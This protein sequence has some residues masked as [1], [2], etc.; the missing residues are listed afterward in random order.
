MSGV[1][2]GTAFLGPLL[3]LADS[4]E[5]LYRLKILNET[6]KETFHE[7]FL[8]I[9]NL[10]TAK[11]KLS[12]LFQTVFT[13]PPGQNK[14]LFQSLTGYNFYCS[15]NYTERPEVFQKYI[16][17]VNS[18][19]FKKAIHVGATASLRSQMMMTVY[20]MGLGDFFQDINE[21]VINV[22]KNTNVLLYTGEWDIVFPAEN[23]WRFYCALNWSQSAGFQENDTKPWYPDGKSEKQAGLFAKAGSV[24]YVRVDDAGHD[25]GFDQSEV[26]YKMVSLFLQNKPFDKT[27]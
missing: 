4:S 3:T 6:Q 27:N 26:A 14:T 5:F 13:K 21:T 7:C 24:T 22:L 8:E 20:M 10:K 25:P 15:V 17:F 11:E 1:I 18:S 2:G 16:S 19:H 12:L 23:L 9:G